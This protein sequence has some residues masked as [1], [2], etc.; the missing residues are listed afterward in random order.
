MGSRKSLYVLGSSSGDTKAHKKTRFITM[1]N[2]RGSVRRGSLWKEYIKSIHCPCHLFPYLVK[3][4]PSSEIR[5]IIHRKICIRLRVS[6]I[7][8]S[9]GIPMR[10]VV[11]SY[12]M[13]RVVDWG[14]QEHSSASK[15]S[16][17]D[18]ADTKEVMSDFTVWYMPRIR[19]DIISSASYT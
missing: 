5:C 8:S 19:I 13:H 16:T 17:R 11:T 18:K 1:S 9:T 3:L 10:I 12:R 2:K 14:I 6:A 4:P 7:P 15:K